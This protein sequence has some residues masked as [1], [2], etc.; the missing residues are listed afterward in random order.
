[1]IQKFIIGIVAN[2]AGLYLIGKYVPGAH[3]PLTIQGLLIAAAVLALI[4]FV[5][6]PILKLVF[7]PLIIVTLGFATLIV[8]GL[9]LYILERVVS[10]VSFDGLTPLGYATLIMTLVNFVI[11]AI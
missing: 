9:T 6:R 2:G 11:H 3:V 10:S 4:N 8:N 7:T 5:I 1:M